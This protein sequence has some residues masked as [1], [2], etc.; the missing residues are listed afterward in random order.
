MSESTPARVLLVANRT[1]AT[2]GMIDAVRRRAHEGQCSFH[3]A[4]PPT[5]GEAAFGEEE[6]RK[7]LETAACR[8]KARRRVLDARLMIDSVKSRRS[9]GRAEWLS[10]VASPWTLLSRRHAQLTTRSACP[11]GAAA[12]C[13]GSLPRTMAGECSRRPV[14]G[15][16]CA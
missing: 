15:R 8:A 9:R 14:A 10:S 7:T 5:P 1:A 11:L 16:R 3:A 13:E 4:D 2:P 12:V 6:A